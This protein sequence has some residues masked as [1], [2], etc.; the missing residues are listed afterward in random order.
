[1]NDINRTKFAGNISQ[2][3][4]SLHSGFSIPGTTIPTG[5]HTPGF[6]AAAGTPAAFEAALKVGRALALVGW[7]VLTNDEAY[8]RV[9]ADFQKSKLEQE[10]AV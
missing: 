3:I 10:E 6:A 7:E 9:A 4:P 8:S 2:A 1:L 5:P